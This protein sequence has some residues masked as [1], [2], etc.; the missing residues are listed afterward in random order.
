MR[1][2]HNRATITAPQLPRH[3]DNKTKEV[4][5]LSRFNR[6]LP[7]RNE[8]LLKLFIVILNCTWIFY[9]DIVKDCPGIT[10]DRPHRQ[11]RTKHGKETQNWKIIFYWLYR[12]TETDRQTDR[13]TDQQTNR[14]T[15]RGRVENNINYYCGK[16]SAWENRLK[17]K[18]AI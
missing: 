2:D 3:Q 6:T 5:K 15:D 10:E 14:P 16:I 18:S 1:T 11:E 4:K 9:H 13:P 12:K 7:G 8:I 17:L